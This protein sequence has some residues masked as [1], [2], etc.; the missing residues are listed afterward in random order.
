MPDSLKLHFLNE[1]LNVY[2]FE[3][4]ID[5]PR[6]I[7]DKTFCSVT[8][9]ENEV[10][11]VV[12]GDLDPEGI[13]SNTEYCSDDW[14]A[15]FVEGPLPHDMVGVMAKLSKCIADIGCSIFAIATFDT[16][17]IL[18]PGNKLDTVKSALV[19]S[20]YTIVKD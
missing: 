8:K 16:D 17:Y 20:G 9:V 5:L 15:F 2:R 1:R 3:P 7:W 4:G 14:A 18:V 10:S 6:T 13:P 19:Q 11:V 12:S